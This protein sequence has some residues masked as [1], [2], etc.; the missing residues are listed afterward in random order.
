MNVDKLWNSAVSLENR[1][2]WVRIG[3]VDYGVNIRGEIYNTR[4][5]NHSRY[6]E[7]IIGSIRLADKS[8]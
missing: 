6:G 3:E 8:E 5:P 4:Y 1:I 7:G 2:Y